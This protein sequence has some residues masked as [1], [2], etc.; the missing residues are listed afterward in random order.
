MIDASYTATQP[1]VALALL[2]MTAIASV[3]VA[4]LH[5]KLRRGE[6]KRAEQAILYQELVE[7]TPSIIYRVD[8]DLTCTYM[9]PRLEEVTGWPPDEAIGHNMLEWAAARYHPEERAEWEQVLSGTLLQGRVAMLRRQRFRRADDTYIYLD[10]TITPTSDERG[11]QTGW[12]GVALDVTAEVE[13][14][15]RYRHLIEQ[16]PGA[17]VLRY[18]PAERRF[19]F[20]GGNVE[21]LTGAPAERWLE[22]GGFDAFTSSM[23]DPDV[24]DWEER[25]LRGE[26]WQNQFG[27]TRQD[28]GERVELRSYAACIGPDEVQSVVFDITR[29]VEQEQQDRV[30]LQQM[31]GALLRYDVQSGE[32]LY[33]GG[34]V[35]Q[36]TGYPAEHWLEGGVDALVAAIRHPAV[37]NWLDRARRGGAWQNEFDMAHPDGRVVHVRSFA[38]TVRP[39]L[40]QTILV[41]V[42]REVEEE[43]RFQQL[44]EQSPGA[45]FRYNIDEWR[46][47]FVG[48]HV[49]ELTGAPATLWLEPD[50]FERFV[51]RMLTPSEPDWQELARR[52]NESWQ[53]Q[54]GFAR[55]DTGKR[56]EILSH[57]AV[58]GGGEVQAVVF[59]VTHEMAEERRFQRLMEQSPGA[60]FRYNIHERR[61]TFVGGHSEEL[62]GAPAARWMLP[63]GFEHFIESML[64]PIVPDWQQRALRGE[65]WQNQ[66]GFTRAD[67]GERVEL[68]TYSAIAGEGEVQAVVYD[69][70]RE[71]QDELRYQ[72]LLEQTPGAVARYDAE[73]GEVLYAGGQIEQLLGYP[74]QH[75]LGDGGFERFRELTHGA[76]VDVRRRAREG[77]SWQ[78][79]FRYEHPDGREMVIRSWAALVTGSV[80][81]TIMLD[82]TEEVEAA[83][84][85]EA[86]RDRRRDA[87]GQLVS[88]GEAEQARI[89]EELHD[90][91][92]QV[93]TAVL[94]RL[95]MAL[96]G[97][98]E[99]G[100]AEQLLT[101]AMERTRSLMFELRPQVLDVHGLE[102]ALDALA[103]EGPWAEQ[104]VDIDL[105]RQSPTTEALAYRTIREL[106]VNARK[107]SNAA[108]L[109]ITGRQENGSLVFE[110][111]DDGVGFDLEKALDR[112]RMRLHIGLDSTIE[113]VRLA[114]GELRIDS[115]PGHG[116]R[117]SLTLPAD[118]ADNPTA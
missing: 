89:A 14:E 76:R 78:N 49:E 35:E 87:L 61:Y 102:P 62:T 80:V 84:R 85:L 48:G 45:I 81:Q 55:V 101:A 114:D 54:F 36:V 113:R 29:E 70:T 23:I 19:T 109:S 46:F 66:F 98:P 95:R 43:L 93:M 11:H 1:D 99:L 41:D 6:R 63:D 103:R 26:N 58:V 5:V 112:G 4:V 44:L 47:L 88:A 53:N 104:T 100:E 91:V 38:R 2:G 52:P 3:G 20:A 22:P 90:D 77:G 97:N 116:T 110:V 42:T 9:S 92:V 83:Q 17:V 74:A 15:T 64:D 12:Q 16:T 94:M 37:P 72:T 51:S 118:P 30:L 8:Q 40:A 96:P 75:W 106:V 117:V 56:V 73:T 60:I 33:A 25:A 107:H 71:V 65:G 108:H 86:E 79:E 105:P 50:G 68:R 7:N 10:S 27:F 115:A 82:V 24:T 67:T 69:V 18:R 39:G 32:M 21:E 31:P 59:D 34:Q 28:T 13:E 57:S 111:R